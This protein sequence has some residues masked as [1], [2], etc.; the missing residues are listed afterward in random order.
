MD[1]GR[2]ARI[3]GAY[4]CTSRRA[5]KSRHAAWAPRAHKTALGAGADAL[6]S[7]PLRDPAHATY[8]PACPASPRRSEPSLS[9]FCEYPLPTHS[10]PQRRN[11]A[12]ARELPVMPQR[13]VGARFARQEFGAL[14]GLTFCIT[15]APY[16]A[17]VRLDGSAARTLT[18]W[19]EAG[20]G[21]LFSRPHK[22][23]RA[24][25]FA[26]TGHC[27]HVTCERC[28][29]ARYPPL[30]RTLPPPSTCSGAPGG[31]QPKRTWFAAFSR[32]WTV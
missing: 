4:H 32:I 8:L 11:M 5:A 7:P 15:H 29:P 20:R 26:A 18:C 30:L 25:N 27:A 9:P 3:A 24:H 12:C 19:K 31:P 22:R 10:L 14:R 2:A 1:R 6:D 28:A 13:L 16:A 23:A 21:S 17:A